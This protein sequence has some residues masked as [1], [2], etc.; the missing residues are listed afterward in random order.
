MT[1][2]PNIHRQ[3]DFS[4]VTTPGTNRPSTAAQLAQRSLTGFAAGLAAAFAMNLF[5][6]AV[7]DRAGHGAQPPQADRPGDDAT[8]R[9]G[10]AVYHAATGAEPSHSTRAWLGT[11]AHYAFGGTMGAGYALLTGI[12]PRVRT[13]H[14]ALYGTAIWV[15]FDET[16]L[17]TLGLSRGGRELPPRVHAYALAGHCVYGVALESVMRGLAGLGSRDHHA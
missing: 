15:V 11:A 17:P 14:G 8:V 13:A 1:A 16:V 9:V 12:A 7:S 4:I 5:A 10:R 6:R 3:S 2:Y